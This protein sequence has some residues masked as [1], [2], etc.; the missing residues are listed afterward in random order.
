MKI[1]KIDKHKNLNSTFTT[2]HKTDMNITKTNKY[3]KLNSTSTT[4]HKTEHNYTL[5]NQ[6]INIHKSNK[7]VTKL[8]F[9][10][11]KIIKNIQSTSDKYTLFI[12]VTKKSEKRITM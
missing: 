12:A 5:V 3:N 6:A 1:T 7:G 10:S 11:K 9:P 4:E 8:K 2:Q